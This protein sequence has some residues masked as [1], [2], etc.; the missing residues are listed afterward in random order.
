MP[1]DGDIIA[2]PSLNAAPR[3]ANTHTATL[4][5]QGLM[6]LDP[7]ELEVKRRVGTEE[8]RKHAEKVRL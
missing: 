1:C 4:N 6:S 2:S 3:V 5:K 7:L 8:E